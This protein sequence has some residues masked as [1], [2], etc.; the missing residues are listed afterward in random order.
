QTKST[1]RLMKRREALRLLSL[2]TV[3]AL[4]AACQLQ[5]PPEPPPTPLPTAPPT[6]IVLPTPTLAPNPAMRIALDLDPD[7]L[8]PAGQTNASVETIVDYLA[9][10]LVDL[11]PDGKIVPGLAK[12]WDVS[13]DG[14]VYT[15]ELRS[16]VHFHDGSLLTAEVVKGSFERFLNPKLRV[17]V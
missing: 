8:D 7:T 2:G 9:E 16:D 1:M 4:G 10:T 12:K 17:A 13:P 11:Q 5:A 14:R 3:A 15:F 6:P